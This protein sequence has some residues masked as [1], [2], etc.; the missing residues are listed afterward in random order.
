M[1]IATWLRQEDHLGMEFKHMPR[2]CR[3]SIKKKK[4]EMN[5]AQK[6]RKVSFEAFSKTVSNP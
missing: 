4:N 1:P 2:Q 5:T 6:K 3:V